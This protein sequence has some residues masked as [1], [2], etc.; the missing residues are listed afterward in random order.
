MLEDLLPTHS[1][2]LHP[3]D[4]V[5]LQVVVVDFG[6]HFPLLGD[7]VTKVAGL[8]R[9]HA[10]GTGTGGFVLVIVVWMPVRE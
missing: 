9:A 7:E 3:W 1:H 2:D 4:N 8:A 6:I 10:E 5:F